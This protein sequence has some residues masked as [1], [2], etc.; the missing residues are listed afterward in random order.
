MRKSLNNQIL[1][2][3]YYR[4]YKMKKKNIVWVFIHLHKTGGT[5]FNVHLAK[6]L[7]NR[8]LHLGP[9]KNQLEFNKLSRKEK[10]KIRAIVGHQVYYGIHKIIPNKNYRY[11]TFLR[12]PAERL[13]SQYN[14]YISAESSEKEIFFEEWYANYPKNEMTR[15]FSKRFKPRKLIK[16]SGSSRDVLKYIH[17]ASSW[18]RFVQALKTIQ[19]NIFEKRKIKTAKKLLNNCWFVGITENLDDD[20]RFICNHI[21]ISTNWKNMRVADKKE[22]WKEDFILGNSKPSQRKFTLNEKIR[23]RIYEENPLDI[24]IYNYA[25]KLNKRLKNE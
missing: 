12:D 19:T 6:E 13:V 7:R 24:E 10:Q 16:F 14:H 3:K 1:F 15:F 25:K 9:R 5:T 21:G 17:T 2:Y 20:L 22:S 18:K 8:L 23:Q 4:I 11:I